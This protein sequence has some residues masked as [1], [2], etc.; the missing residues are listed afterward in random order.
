MTKNGNVR[1][2]GSGRGFLAREMPNRYERRIRLLD[3]SIKRVTEALARKRDPKEI[4]RAKNE[5]VGMNI[6]RSYVMTQWQEADAKKAKRA[7]KAAEKKDDPK[8]CL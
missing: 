8:Q 5:I 1:G 3:F 7:A 6:I 4:E 2:V